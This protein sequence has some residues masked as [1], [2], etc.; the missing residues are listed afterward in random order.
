MFSPPVKAKKTGNPL[1]CLGKTLLNREAG[2]KGETAI[3]TG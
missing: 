2:K 3:P 1:R